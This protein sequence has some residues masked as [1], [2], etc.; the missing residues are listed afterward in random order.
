MIDRHRF[1]HWPWRDS[2]LR[3]PLK[4]G[5]AVLAMA[6]VLGLIPRGEGVAM[7]AFAKRGQILAARM[8]ATCHAIGRHD[9]SPHVS[10][11]MF[12]NLERHMDLGELVARLRRGPIAGHEDMP[13]F[14]F[15]RDE[16]QAIVAY[17]KSIQ[18]P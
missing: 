10:A 2:H 7:D 4:G 3:A 6:M 17:L 13:V 1:L 14:R 15:T 18:A 9:S 5:L 8:C 16:A 12:R 11:P